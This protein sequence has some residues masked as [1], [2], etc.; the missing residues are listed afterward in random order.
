MELVG[1]KFGNWTII[2]EAPSKKYKTCSRK[3]LTCK[4]DC[5]TIRNIDKSALLNGKTTNCGCRGVFLREGEQ[6]QEWTVLSKAEPTQD[7]HN[8]QQYLCKCSCG[9][10]RVVRMA[11]LKNGNSINCGHDRY[12][13]SKG[14]QKIQSIL[15]QLDIPYF[16]EYMFSD[17]PKRRYDFAIYDKNKEIIRLIEFDGEQHSINSKSSWHS[18]DLIKRDLE[19]NKYALSHKIPLVRIPWYKENIDY[20]DLFGEK[21]LVEEE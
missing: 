17:F 6:Y 18:E 4:C 5:G 19:K 2:G 14:A 11:D 10:E 13:L 9:V 16:M 12:F 7:G 8:R 1:K 20:E 21:F 15:E 3:Q